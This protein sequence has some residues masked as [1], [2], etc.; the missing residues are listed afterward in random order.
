MDALLDLLSLIHDAFFRTLAARTPVFTSGRLLD[1]LSSLGCFTLL[2]LPLHEIENLEITALL[3]RLV[4]LKFTKC[5][6]ALFLHKSL[7]FGSV[8]LVF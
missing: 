7:S 3:S 4:L 1:G 6:V 5:L 2:S 8:R